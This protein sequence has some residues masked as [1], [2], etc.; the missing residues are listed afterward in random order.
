ME[1]RAKEKEKNEEDD[2]EVDLEENRKFLFK[3]FTQFE[4]GSRTHTH[5]HCSFLHNS[6]LVPLALCCGA[7]GSVRPSSGGGLI[8]LCPF[9]MAA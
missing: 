7:V 4:V 9:S 1:A 2:K 8:T 3:T 6:Y 5:T